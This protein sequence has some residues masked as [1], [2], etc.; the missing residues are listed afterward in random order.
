MITLQSIGNS[1]RANGT[2]LGGYINVTYEQLTDTLGA[3]LGP[4]PD[5]KVLAEWHV[6][7]RDQGE[8]VG[9]ATI[10]NYKT[11]NNYDPQGGL[12][13]QDIQTWHVGT[14]HAH[15]YSYINQFFKEQ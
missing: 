15:E 2:S 6:V 7:I 5:N 10:Y 8:D 9:F 1:K 14:K 13:V 3:S 12:N 4:S 11:G